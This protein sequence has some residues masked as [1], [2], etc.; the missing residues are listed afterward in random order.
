MHKED[1]YVVEDSMDFGGD[2]DS[3]EFVRCHF[4]SFFDVFD[5]LEVFE[6]FDN[7]L[8]FIVYFRYNLLQLINRAQQ[9]F[10]RVAIEFSSMKFGSHKCT[11]Y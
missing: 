3:Q 10:A 2:T 5:G 1:L 11:L 4:T 8:N 6:N 7:L 9:D